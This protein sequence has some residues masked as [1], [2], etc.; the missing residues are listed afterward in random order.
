MINIK[1]KT[2]LNWNYKGFEYSLAANAYTQ[3][4]WNQTLITRIN[5]CSAI[6]YSKSVSGGADTIRMNSKIFEIVKSFEYYNLNLDG[7]LNKYNVIVDDMIFDDVIYVY[8]ARIVEDPN[9]NLVPNKD[10]VNKSFVVGNA[11]EIKKYKRSLIAK[12]EILNNS[13]DEI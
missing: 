3:K 1:C 9:Y 8:S 2:K 7:K 11:K 12:I 6:I 4:D 13:K 5:Q 10:D